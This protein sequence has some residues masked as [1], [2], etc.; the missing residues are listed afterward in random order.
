MFAFFFRFLSFLFFLHLFF[1]SAAV[2]K[3]GKSDGRNKA[4]QYEE[5]KRLF[6]S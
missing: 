1:V 2:T 5:D 4:R 6:H 3:A